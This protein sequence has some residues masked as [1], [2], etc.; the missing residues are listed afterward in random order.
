MIAQVDSTK[1]LYYGG[2]YNQAAYWKAV[3]L[4]HIK[5]PQP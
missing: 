2:Y 1:V 3:T 5:L 4:G